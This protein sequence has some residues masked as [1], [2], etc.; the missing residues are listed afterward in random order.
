FNRRTGQEYPRAAVAEWAAEI[1]LPL[2]PQLGHLSLEDMMALQ[3]QRQD[4]EGFVIRF[5]DGRRVKVKTQWY[6]EIARI[7]ADLTPIAVWQAMRGGKVRPEYLARLPEEL[8]PLA[9][10]YQAV[11][12]GQYARALLEV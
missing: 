12:E 5:C 1:G 2:V 10:K 11:L 9:E 8:R 7:M 6:L 4:F 3:K